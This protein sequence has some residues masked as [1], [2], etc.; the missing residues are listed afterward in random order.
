MPYLHLIERIVS[1]AL[2]RVMFTRVG[3]PGIA[4]CA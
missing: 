2:E 1:S 4:R 3:A